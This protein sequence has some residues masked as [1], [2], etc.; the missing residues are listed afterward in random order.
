MVD[1]VSALKGA[2]LENGRSVLS[3]ESVLALSVFGVR[4]CPC[5]IGCGEDILILC[6]KIECIFAWCVVCG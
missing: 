2:G 1:N 4:G 6:T 5:L 3:M